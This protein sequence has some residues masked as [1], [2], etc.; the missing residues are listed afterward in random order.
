MLSQPRC[1]FVLYFPELSDRNLWLIIWFS[2]HFHLHFLPDFFDIHQLFPHFPKL[3][4]Q[5]LASH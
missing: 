5:T 4:T 3:K 1:F 2:V